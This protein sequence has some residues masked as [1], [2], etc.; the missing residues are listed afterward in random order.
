MFLTL[1][2]SQLYSHHNYP[3]YPYTAPLNN[4]A[5]CLQSHNIDHPNHHCHL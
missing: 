1:E 3:L 5:D 2:R 4:I